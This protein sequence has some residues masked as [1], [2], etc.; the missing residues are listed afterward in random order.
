MRQFPL[1]LPPPATWAMFLD[2]D[3]T[4]LELAETPDAVHPAPG[5]GE[6][7]DDLQRLTSGA[8][9]I[10][11]GRSVSFV[12]Q[13]FPGH[14]HSVAGLHGAEL[15]LGQALAGK[16]CGLA[17][18]VATP[19]SAYL[20]AH[21]F[22]RQASATL[23]GV[24]FEDKGRAFALHYRQAP[25]R[26]DAVLEI[27]RQALAQSG[28]GHGLREGK[29]VVELCPAGQDKGTIIRKLMALAPFSDRFP[30]AAGDDLTDEAMF[31]AVNAFRGLSLRI[32][33]AAELSSSLAIAGLP[34]PGAFRNWIRG[35]IT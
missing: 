24:I 3:G 28:A 18:E 23:P 5:L 11:T 34:S 33:P 29:Y 35:L 27:M 7:L 12:D 17:G 6:M 22:V 2:L 14:C 32:G 31:A 1:V 25:T 20:R 8:L 9:T 4:L 26:R 19:G 13:L 30:M 15:R 16:D 10:V 21:E